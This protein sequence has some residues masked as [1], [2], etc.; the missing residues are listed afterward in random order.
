MV[1]C[2][3]IEFLVGVESASDQILK[4]M[5]KGET[6]EE[7]ASALRKLKKADAPIVKTYWMLG[8]P[9]E[10]KETLEQSQEALR[11]L[12]EQDLTDYAII[13]LFLPYP[14]TPPFQEPERFDIHIE[15]N[16][17]WKYE[18]FSF[19]PPYQLG[20]VSMDTLLDHLIA[21][22]YEQLLHLGQKLKIGESV[23]GELISK[24]LKDEKR[25]EAK[26]NN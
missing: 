13:K 20:S 5:N 26:A 6:Y 23:L 3:F 18:R 17:W 4:K 19:P 24:G 2:G 14:G 7:I 11:E 16:H 15:K 12:L 10:T 9:G 21:M 8:F 25:R 1:R 22:N